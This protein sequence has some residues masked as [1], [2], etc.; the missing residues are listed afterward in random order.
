M[1]AYAE[2]IEKILT[3]FV[4]DFMSKM[5]VKSQCGRLGI[6]PQTI[7]PQHLAPL[8]QKIGL[9]LSISVDKAKVS[10]IVAQIQAIK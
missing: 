4:G 3:P 8:S 9:A 10:A 2:Q 1:P 7:G 5:A 6:T